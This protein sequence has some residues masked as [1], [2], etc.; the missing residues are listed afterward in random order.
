[1]SEAALRGH[2]LEL[3]VEASPPVGGTFVVLGELMDLTFPE[4]Q[5]E[6]TETTAHNDVI[7][8]YTPSVFRRSEIVGEFNYL[9]TDAT[10]DAATG[11]QALVISCELFGL[12]IRGPGGSA[13]VDET[14]MSGY[15][16]AF[17]QVS[18]VR[19]GQRTAT[20]TFR[21]SGDMKIDGTIIVPD[22][23]GV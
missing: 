13:G 8:S 23:V 4:F 5:R 14:I 16:T 15:V 11:L 17:R 22:A 7:D 10:H 19:N 1:M 21:P 12:R 2:G 18:P 3:A 20:F 9:L 6:T